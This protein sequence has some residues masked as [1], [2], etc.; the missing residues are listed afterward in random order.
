MRFASQ[1]ARARARAGL[2]LLLAPI[3]GGCEL[4]Y[5]VDDRFTRGTVADAGGGKDAATGDARTDDGAPGGAGFCNAL[6]TKPLFCDDFDTAPLSARWST[7]DV[8][9]SVDTTSAESPP[10]SLLS[11]LLSTAGAGS[12]ALATQGF[13]ASSY[14]RTH[15][16]VAIRYDE[17]TFAQ[18]Y[19]VTSQSIE[20]TVN[21]TGCYAILY[22]GKAALVVTEQ[23]KGGSAAGDW[24]HSG[25]VL[26]PP[27][28][29]VRGGVDVHNTA[30]AGAGAL[31][32]KVDGQTSIAE[33]LKGTCP[34]A[35]G[36]AY[37]KVGFYNAPADST[38]RQVRF[39]DLTFDAR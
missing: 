35:P 29:V 39:D 17:S 6:A 18:P 16:S 1:Q 38:D 4:A 25:S 20:D 27:G 5:P 13:A 14:S 31:S 10:R 15:L 32:V 28:R 21:A 12:Y 3:A 36:V 19:Y 26:V 24:S 2:A 11:R 34:Y 22:V 30:G 7:I 8:G 9:V 23:V 33:P 37:V